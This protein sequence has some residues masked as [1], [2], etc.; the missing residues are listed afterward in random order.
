MIEKLRVSR[1][2]NVYLTLEKID[3]RH[4]LR[5]SPIKT[6]SRPVVALVLVSLDCSSHLNAA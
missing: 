5:G 2:G 6:A 3:I 1:A 4:G